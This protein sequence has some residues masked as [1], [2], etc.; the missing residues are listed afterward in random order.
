MNSLKWGIFVVLLAL[1]TLGLSV[2][3]Q[4]RWSWF[5]ALA[6]MLAL[7]VM[8]RHTWGSWNTLSHLFVVFLMLYTLSGPFE[9]LFGSG[10][11]PPFQPPF[12]TSAWLTDVAMAGIGFTV[13]TLF[14]RL[15]W[16]RPSACKPFSQRF[17]LFGY[18]AAFLCAGTLSEMVNLM[19]AGGVST[20]LAGKAVYQAT[21][22]DLRLTLPSSIVAMIGFAFSG[23]YLSSSRGGRS[24]AIMLLMACASPLLIIHLLLGQ[25]LEL[26]S[27]ALTFLLAL[28]YPLS[29][30]RFPAKAIAI[31][32]FVYLLIAPLYGF[33]WA[34]PMWF[35]GQPI[36]I[37][38]ETVRRLFLTSLNP[39]VNEFGS[40]FGNY[41]LQQQAGYDDFL[42]GTSYF[43]ELTIVIPSFLYPGEKPQSLTYEFRDRFF[44]VWATRSRIAGTAFSNILEARLNFGD[45]GPALVFFFYGI[46]LAL[47]ERSRVQSGSVW[48]AVFYSTFTLWAMTVHRSTTGGALGNALWVLL[49]LGVARIIA[50]VWY[51]QWVMRIQKSSS[52][53]PA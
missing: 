51:P 44:P 19:R 20:L 29:I 22:A 8:L 23:L 18:A 30:P 27:Y 13:G 39:A 5:F 36:E 15:L 26:G 21:T 37:P 35:S 43:R 6:T 28:T 38:P 32:L 16:G 46:L 25:R 2:Y 42:Y 52:S 4:P 11:I 24:R 3:E 45:Y 9:V 31:A 34:F 33:R 17:N 53:S 47:M 12:A 7:L 49:L 1:G 10:E 48:F 14:V 40:A 41:S 50:E